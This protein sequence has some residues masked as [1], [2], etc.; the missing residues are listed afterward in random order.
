MIRSLVVSS[1]LTLGFPQSG[2]SQ[3]APSLGEQ[4]GAQPVMMAYLPMPQE[5]GSLRLFFGEAGLQQNDRVSFSTLWEI[6]PANDSCSTDP[7][8]AVIDNLLF[9]DVVM[10]GAPDDYENAED[11]ITRVTTRL[12]LAVRQHGLELSE[13]LAACQARFLTTYSSLRETSPSTSGQ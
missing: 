4:A 12:T 9:S 3:Q 2:L 13:P 1:L 10:I 7:T 8:S 6:A 5:D 11:I